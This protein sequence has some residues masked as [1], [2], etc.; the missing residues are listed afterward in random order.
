MLVGR[1]SSN[2]H[3]GDKDMGEGLVLKGI[4]KKSDVGFLTLFE[5]YGYFQVGA[6]LKRPHLPIWVVCSE[7]HYSILFSTDI[8]L[9]L[10]P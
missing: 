6:N 7:S 10:Q 8:N 3:D 4:Q 5:H 9:V 2:V 1:G